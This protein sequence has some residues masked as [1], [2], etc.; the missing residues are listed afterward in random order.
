MLGPRL[1]KL[2]LRADVQ[3]AGDHLLGLEQFA[4]GGADS[5]RG[6]RENERVRDNGYFLSLEWRYPIWKKGIDRD[7]QAAVFTDMGS[8][9][10]KGES[11][12]DGFLHSLGI[13][14]LWKMNRLAR[15]EI[16][17]A[18]DLERASDKYEHNLQDD[19]IHFRFT[20]DFFQAKK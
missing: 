9:W 14:F 15:A 13:G 16:Y 12:C 8:A 17:L 10:N 5:V 7:I 20:M 18:H 19:G 4:L 11:S 3:L 6:Y 1:G 2:V